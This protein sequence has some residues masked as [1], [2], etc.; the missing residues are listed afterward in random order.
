[1]LV[2]YNAGARKSVVVSLGYTYSAKPDMICTAATRSPGSPD[3]KGVSIDTNDTTTATITVLR[4]TDFGTYVNWL[5]WGT[6][7]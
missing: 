4:E 7:W 1:V 3:V 5:S 2:P 6:L